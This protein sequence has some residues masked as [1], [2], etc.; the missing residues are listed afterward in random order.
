[1]TQRLLDRIAIITGGAS[2]VGKAACRLFAEHGA[3]VVVADL[4]LERAQAVAEDCGGDAVL[5][6]VS[7]ED[8]W[9]NLI[10]HC[11]ERHGRLDILVNSAGIGR[12]GDFEN[13]S[14]DDWNAMIAVNMTG[15]FF[16]CKHGVSAMRKSST[17]GS[18]IN[19]SSLAGLVGGE[20]IAGY[21]ATKGAVTMLT[22]SVALHAAKYG[23]RCNSVHP[24]Y[25]DSE[26]LDD[27][28]QRFPS[29]QAMLDGMASL[30]PLGRVAKPIDIAEAILFLASDESSLITGSPLIIDGGQLA[31]LPSRHNG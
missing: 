11:L 22:K 20:D 15:V 8:Q 18:I 7:K 23:I 3:Q 19:I 31:G 26:M 25:V 10:E 1:M 24:T 12:A 27:V 30:V 13:L 16:G 9:R 5:L 4:H 2:G 6:D 28:A 17:K 21:S 29:R 14:A